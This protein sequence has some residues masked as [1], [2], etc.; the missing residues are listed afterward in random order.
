MIDYLIVFLVCIFAS[1]ILPLIRNDFDKILIFFLIALVLITFSGIR[2]Y[3]GWDFEIYQYMYDSIFN[4]RDP[5]AI[6]NSP[7]Y[8]DFE[9]GFRLFALTARISPYTPV[10]LTCMIAVGASFFVMHKAPSR[11]FG[12]FIVL[13]LWYEY[14][15]IFS[16]QRQIVAHAIILIGLYFS[17]RYQ[18]KLFILIFSP[19]AFIFHVS[20]LFASLFYFLAYVFTERN[21]RFEISSGFVLVA[22]SVF[23]ILIPF[24]F[25]LMAF[26]LS[27][28]VLSYLG[29]IGKHA[30]LKINY[31]FDYLALY[32]TGLSFRYFEYVL[33]FLFSLYKRECVLKEVHSKYGRYLFVLSLN[34]SALHILCYGALS[35]LG[36]IQERVECYFFLSH[37]ILMSYL[38]LNF[39]KNII[40]YLIVLGLCIS[41]VSVKYYRLINS[42][43]YIGGDSH[44]Q[45]FIPY[46]SIFS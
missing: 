37:V 4:A 30:S 17:I 22:I 29:D 2:Y 26:K 20:S 44:Y 27:T 45:R 23:L 32:K 12:V 39:S 16:I 9:L 34:M 14:F 13:Y 15:S 38:S 8:K 46:N 28:V 1:V 43:P 21:F 25:S 18:S 24:D 6:I 19:L 41:F 35:G 36:V 11:T 42:D 7:H 3:V 10:F 31:Y 33:V 40:S 5:I